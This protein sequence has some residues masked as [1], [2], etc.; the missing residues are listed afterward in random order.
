MTDAELSLERLRQHVHDSRK[1]AASLRFQY[2]LA[3]EQ[4]ARNALT[5]QLGEVEAKLSEDERKLWEVEAQLAGKG[6][7]ADTKTQPFLLGSDTTGLE[8]Q[9]QLRM[10]YV[11]TG[12]Y[13]L[14]DA[15]K[16]P[17]V[18][19]EIRNTK[20]KDT[21][22]VRVTAYVEGFS[23]SAVESFELR[24]LH[25]RTLCLSP[26]LFP[27]ASRRLNEITRATLNVLVEDLDGKTELHRT[28]P[29]WLLARNAA[30]L[31][32]KDPGTGQLMDMTKYLG[33]FVTPNEPTIMQ[34]LRKV[35]DRHPETRLAG[36]QSDVVPQVRA[37]FD[38]L[39]ED[40]KIAYVNSL[41]A[42]DPAEGSYSQ[43]VRMPRESLRQRQANC[44]DGTL[45]FAS[46]LEAISLNAALVILRGHALVA[47]QQKEGSTKWSYLDTV[48]IDRSTFEV[49][50]KIAES[51]VKPLKDAGDAR[52]FRQWS[53][54]DLRVHHGIYPME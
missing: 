30:P 34:F 22:R 52:L 25:D 48:E 53:V 38:T 18:S 51:R 23:A 31:E 28:V 40:S 20:G 15:E 7:I 13:H 12:I 41:I 43:R 47:W 5:Q 46:L 27:A 35:A 8:V 33:A 49:A 32:L 11:P 45:L 50:R 21:R 3:R 37:I 1:A 16:H 2:D 9:I 42:F 44:V 19:F 29:I 4:Q 54:R 17:M 6:V 26:T 39:K 24:G 10:A 14:L 36:Y